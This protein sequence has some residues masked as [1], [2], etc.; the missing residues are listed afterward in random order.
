MNRQLITYIINGEINKD[1]T[2]ED[3]KK[4]NFSFEKIYAESRSDRLFDNYHQYLKLNKMLYYTLCWDQDNN[5]P[6][7]FT[8]AQHMTENCCRLFSRYYLFKKYRTTPSKTNLY[9]KIDNFET[10]F[11]HLSLIETRY[12][13][14]FWS[15]DKGTGFFKR[16][17]KFKHSLFKNWEIYPES[18][19]LIWKNNYQGIFYINNQENNLE[20][21]IDELR[22]SK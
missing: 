18:I 17:K 16:L 14:I 1:L 3:I 9:D 11:Y 12:P 22:F 8:G 2:Q 10:D 19:E 13:F 4:V 20:K 15:R 21:Y 6:I 5:E 7:L